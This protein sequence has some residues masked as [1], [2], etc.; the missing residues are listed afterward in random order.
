MTPR[1]SS[2]VADRSRVSIIAIDGPASSGKS[3]IGKELARILDFLYFD[4]GVMYRAVTCR[5]LS[6]GLDVSDEK[7]ITDLAERLR[8]EVRP[9]TVPDGR[10]NDLLADGADITWKIRAPEVDAAV[11]TVAAFPGVRQALN[12]HLRSIGSR[13]RI[14]MV[15]RDIGTVVMPE[16]DVKIYLMASPEERALRRFRERGGRGEPADY[17]E[18]LASIRK[19]DALDSSRET[20]PLRLAPDA[21]FINSD[22]ITIPEVVDQVLSL[23]RAEQRQA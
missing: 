14:V 7:S 13:G 20:A 23:V 2:Q 22:G 5:A 3:T 19:R 17:A 8:I 10:D 12:R 15:G 11:S 1:T 21:H 4:S 16:A 18:I 9:A 6:L